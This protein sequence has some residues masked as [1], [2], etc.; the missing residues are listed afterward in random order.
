M[1][2]GCKQH[3]NCKLTNVCCFIS[4]YLN[5]G[6]EPFYHK[7]LSFMSLI[8]ILYECFYNTESTADASAMVYNM[9]LVRNSYARGNVI[10][11]FCVCKE[12]A[13]FESDEYGV[14]HALKYFG[15][16]DITTPEDQVITPH[17]G[18]ADVKSKRGWLNGHVKK[19]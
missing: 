7:L 1:V 2:T 4:P 9:N 16:K 12:Y 19:C 5:D 3:R 13:N 8:Q 11:N 17:I 6:R 14:A 18:K 10:D 15:I